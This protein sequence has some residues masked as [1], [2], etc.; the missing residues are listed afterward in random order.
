MRLSAKK[1][2]FGPL[3]RRQKPFTR[4]MRPRVWR[5]LL[6]D[7]AVVLPSHFGRGALLASKTGAF[8]QERAA[9][10]GANA[11]MARPPRLFAVRHPVRSDNVRPERRPSATWQEGAQKQVPVRGES[12]RCGWST[13]ARSHAREELR[14]PQ[15]VALFENPL[16]DG[17]FAPG[18]DRPHSGGLGF[19]RAGGMDLWRGGICDMNASRGIRWG[20]L[21]RVRA[22]ILWRFP[23]LRGPAIRPGALVAPGRSYF[24]RIV[25]QR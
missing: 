5:L 15:E 2:D 22:R 6:R 13:T 4:G 7:A 10:L 11:P 20:V 9:A 3:A 18:L 24:L 17:S 16:R 12:P 23:G 25:L 8:F 14:H 19:V 21:L 1:Q